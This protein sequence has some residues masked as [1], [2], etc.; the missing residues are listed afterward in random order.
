MVDLPNEKGDFD[1]R[2]ALLAK[3]KLPKC[4][5]VV[6]VRRVPSE[7]ALEAFRRE[8]EGRGGRGL[9]LRLGSGDSN[10]QVWKLRVSPEFEATKIAQENGSGKNADRVGVLICVTTSGQKFR[11]A[12]G[13]T[14]AVRDNPPADGTVVICR[15]SALTSKG[16]PKSPVFVR[17]RGS[18]EEGAAAPAPAAKPSSKRSAG[19][20]EKVARIAA[21]LA[22]ESKA[23]APKRMEMIEVSRLVPYEEGGL[24]PNPQIHDET[25]L[26]RIRRSIEKFKWVSPILIDEND[27]VL[28]GNGRRLVAMEMGLVRVPCI[29]ITGLTVDEKRIVGLTINNLGREARVDNEKLAFQLAQAQAA[30]EFTPMAL[31]ELGFTAE[32]T[33][34][35]SA[36]V[37]TATGMDDLRERFGLT[38]PEETGEPGAGEDSEE[39]YAGVKV[40]GSLILRPAPLMKLGP[41]Q[42]T[43]LV[44][45]GGKSAM[46]R[47]LRPVVECVD[48]A[49]FYYEAFAGGLA[50]LWSFNSPFPTEVVSDRSAAVVAFW[51]VMKSD[52][53]EFAEM[54]QKRGLHSEHL[55]K[56]AQRILF[57]KEKAE[58]E[59][60]LA[61]SLWYASQNA[62]SYDATQNLLV[63]YE[64]NKAKKFRTRLDELTRERM[65]RL[66]DI[67]VME[68]DAV[69]LIRRFGARRNVL[70]YADPPYLSGAN[71]GPY[72]G[73]TQDEFD[74]LLDALAGCNARWILSSYDNDSLGNMMKKHGWFQARLRMHSSAANTHSEGA[75]EKIEIVTTNFKTPFAKAEKS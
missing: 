73:Y 35:S 57:G 11:V 3:R 1:Q 53:D 31:E 20:G 12:A 22:A 2:R 46:V 15:C 64:D 55:F 51:S 8:V 27:V 43:P 70:I 41:A 61:W 48:D 69:G 10:A 40:E 14:D 68:D 16:N 74:A 63:G 62:G 39:G 21:G 7:A 47:W 60:E 9:M 5:E 65:K 6:E 30:A 58:S 17:V 32:I 26:P 18:G 25:D 36:L 19:K 42:R 71:Q 75:Q 4:C 38:E 72:A 23:K 56:K 34:A 50:L 44:Y 45:H 28:D 24:G 13:L 29:R 66:E 33:A 37:E 54:A 67:T 59:V 52:F 49:T